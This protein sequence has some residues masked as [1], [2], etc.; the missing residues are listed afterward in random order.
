MNKLIYN[1]YIEAAGTVKIKARI[2]N[3]STEIPI[4]LEVLGLITQSDKIRKKSRIA[5][6]L[7]PR[8]YR[9][10]IFSLRCSSRSVEDTAMLQTQKRAQQ[11][12]YVFIT[13]CIARFSIPCL[14]QLHFTSY[15]R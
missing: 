11:V 14:T 2:R 13:S 8:S 1:L 3:Q 7:L 6:L 4:V 15:M 9:R 12:H 10:R 5:S